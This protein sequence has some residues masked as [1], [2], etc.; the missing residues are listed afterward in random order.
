MF[1]PDSAAAHAIFQ[2]NRNSIVTMEPEIIYLSKQQARTFA[3]L[4]TRNS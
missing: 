1:S 4:V 3:F 2:N